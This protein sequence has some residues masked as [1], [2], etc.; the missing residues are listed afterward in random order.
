MVA[1]CQRVYHQSVPVHPHTIGAVMCDG[2]GEPVHFVRDMSAGFPYAAKV[3]HAAELELQTVRGLAHRSGALAETPAGVAGG[4]CGRPVDGHD[5]IVQQILAAVQGTELFDHA[6]FEGRLFIHAWTA[7]GHHASVDRE[8][9]A[10]FGAD[11]DVDRSAQRNGFCQYG[12]V[13]GQLLHRPGPA[14]QAGF[15]FLP[16]T[17]TTRATGFLVIDH[18]QF[19]QGNP[20]QIDTQGDMFIRDYV[21]RDDLNKVRIAKEFVKFNERC[22]MRLLG[23][24]RSVNYVVDITPDFEE[25]QYRVRPIDFDQQSY[26]GSLRVYRSHSFPDNEPI[27]T[28]VPCPSMPWPMLR[29]SYR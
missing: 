25:V 6:L 24:M 12:V 17:V 1:V 28:L 14:P 19:S 3:F 18:G 29:P 9:Q 21:P 7:H 16:L 10:V 13:G 2:S 4:P 27:E 5:G 11:A 23:D 26:E 8:V 20:C 15:V 22:F